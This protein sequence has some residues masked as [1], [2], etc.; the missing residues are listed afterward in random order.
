MA[1][2]TDECRKEAI[3]KFGQILNNKDE[4]EKEFGADSCIQQE[5]A[6]EKIVWNYGLKMRKN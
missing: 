6:I 1:K 5:M 2:I 3:W 4:K